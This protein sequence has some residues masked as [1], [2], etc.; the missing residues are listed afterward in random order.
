MRI[1]QKVLGPMF[2]VNDLPPQCIVLSTGLTAMGF[3]SELVA[4]GVAAVRELYF[5]VAGSRRTPARWMIISLG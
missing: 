5:A 3:S 1:T 4:S 2:W